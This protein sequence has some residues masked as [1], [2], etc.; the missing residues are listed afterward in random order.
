MN[1]KTYPESVVKCGLCGEEYSAKVSYCDETIECAF[2]DG[3]H[4]VS[5]A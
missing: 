1:N 4:L 2:D 3:E 5:V